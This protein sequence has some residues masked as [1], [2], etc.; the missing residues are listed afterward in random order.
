MTFDLLVYF[1]SVRRKLQPE[2]EELAPASVNCQLLPLAPEEV[3]KIIRVFLDSRH[4]K[5]AY[6]SECHMWQCSFESIEGIVHFTV[7]IYPTHD[8]DEVIV[9]FQRV[10]GS[11]LLFGSIFRDFRWKREGQHAEVHEEKPQIKEPPSLPDGESQKAIEALRCWLSFDPLE[12][13]TAIECLDDPLTG[14]IPAFKLL[15]ME[16][17]RERAEIERDYIS[18]IHEHQHNFIPEINAEP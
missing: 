15:K 7:T 6:C 17:I 13:S 12:A 3:E 8:P 1:G 5:K 18:K 4:I 10:S 11:S 14:S 9:E 16:A 2:M